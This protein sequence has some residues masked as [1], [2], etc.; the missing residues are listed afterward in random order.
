MNAEAI[1][2][3]EISKLKRR[4]FSRFVYRIL[5]WSCIFFLGSHTVLFLIAGAQFFGHSQHGLWILL[6]GA[7]S[8]IAAFVVTGSERKAFQSFLID[9][10]ARLQL[11]DCISTAF[12]YQQSGNESVFSDLLMQDATGKLRRLSTREIFPAEFSKLYFF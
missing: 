5:L 8:M 3:G 7:I 10:D 2:V 4:V 11:G 9:I 1:Y 12:E 6:L